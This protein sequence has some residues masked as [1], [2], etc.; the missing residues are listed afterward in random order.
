MGS[1]AVQSRQGTFVFCTHKAG[2]T[3]L[4]SWRQQQTM[5]V[6]LQTDVR[7]ITDGASCH[8]YNILTLVLCLALWRLLQSQKSCVFTPTTPSLN[9]SVHSGKCTDGQTVAVGQ[10]RPQQWAARRRQRLLSFKTSRG[11]IPTAS[12]SVFISPSGFWALLG[13][14]SASFL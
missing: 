11:N 5:A 13:F 2:A 10:R 12:R 1:T 4:C 6:F 9:R 3:S 8:F 14:R 7:Q